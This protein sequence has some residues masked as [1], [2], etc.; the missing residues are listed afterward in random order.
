MK[1]LDFAAASSIHGRG[2]VNEV[3]ASKT[4]AHPKSAASDEPHN[5]FDGPAV[6][7]RRIRLDPYHWAEDVNG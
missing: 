4:L 5:L 6:Y 7:A 3:F 1:L 2:L